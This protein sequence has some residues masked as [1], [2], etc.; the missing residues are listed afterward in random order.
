MISDVEEDGMKLVCVTSVPGASWA[1]VKSVVVP[2]ETLLSTDD[3]VRL[4]LV[5][6]W[7]S[8]LGGKVSDVSVP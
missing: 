8:S 1:E 3:V 6:V 5:G 2:H 4:V 7:V